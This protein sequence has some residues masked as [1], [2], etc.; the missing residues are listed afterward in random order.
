MLAPVLCRFG[1]QEQKRFFLPRIESAEHIWCQGY[2]EPQAGSDLASL[3]T[4]ATLDGD[5]Y[6]VDGTK[7]WTTNAHLSNWMFCLARTNAA[8]KPQNGISFLMIDMKSPGISISPIKLISGDCELNQVFFD[9][10]RVPA[11]NRIGEEGQG[12]TIAKFLLEHERGG[13]CQAPGLL[14][15]IAE[16]RARVGSMPGR[17]GRSLAE[18]GDF[19]HRLAM[20]EIEAR[21]MEMLELRLLVDSASP[22]PQT[23]VLG[24]LMANIRQGIDVLLLEAFGARSLELSPHRPVDAFDRLPMPSYLNNRAWSIM[25]GS[26]EIMRNIIAKAVLKF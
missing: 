20:L 11:G 25:G 24:L 22:G 8:P 6:I 3:R 21:G 17:G 7:I 2:S 1:T 12:W 4:K 15:A 26:N 10:V 16:L 14:T 9:S 13:S 19:M 23:A 18:D 5:A